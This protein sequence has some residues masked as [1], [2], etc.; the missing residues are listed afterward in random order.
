MDMNIPY[1][2]LDG[3]IRYFETLGLPILLGT[4]LFVWAARFVARFVIREY[5]RAKREFLVLSRD[6][7]ARQLSQT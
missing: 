2:W 7:E 1:M 4:L 5:F 6:D 3:T